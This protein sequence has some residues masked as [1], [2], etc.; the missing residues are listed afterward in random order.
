LFAAPFQAAGKSGTLIGMNDSLLPKAETAWIS[1]RARALGFDGCGVAPAEKFPELEHFSDWLDRGYAGEMKYLQDPRRLDPRVPMPGVRSL[2]VCALNYNSGLPYS[3]DTES[4]QDTVGTPRGWI[5]RYAWGDD[6]HEVLW[7]K[8]NALAAEMRGHFSQPFEVRAYADTG[9]V[10]ER[11]AAKYAGLGWLAKNTLLINQSLGSWFFLGVLFTSLPLAPTLGPAEAPPPD[12]CGTCRACLD[13]CPTQAIVKPYVLDASRCIAYLTIELRG[14][15]PEEFREAMERHIFGCD[16][17]Q[18]VCPW[19][20]KS[21]R[22]QLAE[23][24]PRA[25]AALDDTTREETLFLPDLLRVASLTQE[26]FRE[27]FRGS[28]IK[29]TKWQGLVRNA[30]IALGNQSVQPDSDTYREIT[31][32]LQ[33]LSGC[34]D[35]VI[36]ESAHWALS[37]IQAPGNAKLPGSSPDRS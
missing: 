36:A 12:R 6:Y 2:I 27:L 18:D 7:A 17:C 13:A 35:A 11:A 3:T 5:S 37:R 16:I 8:L 10:H 31:K 22:T 19:N 24:K 26:Q 25:L 20:R 9:P 33:S 32:T 29:R 14:A 28:P 21:P 30:C 34:S 15:I 4:N 1:E 23:F